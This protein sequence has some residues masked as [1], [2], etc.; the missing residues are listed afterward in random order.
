MSKKIVE[1]YKKKLAREEGFV[2]KRGARLRI[3]LLPD[4][5]IGAGTVGGGAGFQGG[6]APSGSS[7]SNQGQQGAASAA[8]A[9][10]QGAT[11]VSP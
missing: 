11:G 5:P 1:N 4:L 8:T 2:V 7:S 3:A 9:G 6:A 10:Q